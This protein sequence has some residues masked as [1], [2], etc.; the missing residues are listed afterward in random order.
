[1]KA[2]NYFNRYYFAVAAPVFFLIA[3]NIN[4]NLNKPHIV[5]SKQ[6]E[7]LNLNDEMLQKFNLGFKR[8][9]SSLLWIST[10]LESDI[11]HYKKK[12][13]NS[14]MFRRFNSISKL[15]PKFYE[16]YAF[17]GVYLSIIKDDIEGA[18]ILYHKGLSIYPDDYS[19]LKN[20]SFHFYF[21]AKDLETSYSLFK[22]LEKFPND[23]PFTKL[24]LSK[25]EANN[26][27]LSDAFFMLSEYQKKHPPE[28]MIGKK[29]Y[30]YRYSVKAEID[31]ECLN[32]HQ[33][34]CFKYDLDNN[35][36]LKINHRY[37]AVKP[38]APYRPKWKK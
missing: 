19:L 8:L 14:W 17:G 7:S 1:M 4:Q 36:Y 34:N 29:I 21:E 6:D 18:S 5:I 35:P 32:G 25:L 15:D 27:N 11:D 13:L 23:S 16:N 38:W 24:T 3:Y 10:I 31:L 33:E 26:G 28:T 2:L 12:D 30:D 22:R 37:Q 9:E 20:A